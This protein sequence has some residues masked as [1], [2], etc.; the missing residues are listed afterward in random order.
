MGELRLICPRCGVEYLLPAEAIPP[1]GREVECTACGRI[2]HARRDGSGTPP[3]EPPR[4]LRIIHEAPAPVPAAAPLSRKLPDSVL[5]ILRDEVEHER[6][7][8]MAEDEA[9]G[10]SG[11][12]P[13]PARGV[14]G[15]SVE[16]DWPATTVT[17]TQDAHAAQLPTAQA[18]TGQAPGTESPAP[19]PRPAAVT[20]QATPV[21]T[22]T[23]EPHPSGQMPPVAVAQPAVATAPAPARLDTAGAYRMGLGLAAMLSAACLA[24]YIMAPGLAQTGPAGA[25]LM[26]LRDMVDA[27]RLWLHGRIGGATAG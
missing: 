4:P 20:A 8:R 9:F 25:A 13:V 1:A 21:R 10:R 3:P 17:G 23:P 12:T 14:I 2:W 15:A 6:R 11:A 16:P 24:L 5:D 27:G 18:P 7:A 26:E 19:A 22:I